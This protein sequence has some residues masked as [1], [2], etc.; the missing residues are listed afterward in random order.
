VNTGAAGH[1]AVV[2]R[3][4]RS[5]LWPSG[6]VVMVLPKRLNSTHRAR[7]L[8]LGAAWGTKI[9]SARAPTK[10]LRCWA[11]AEVILFC[12]GAKGERIRSRPSL[13]AG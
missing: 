5:V 2:A 8:L 6:T 9:V 13:K 7:V 4:D 3:L 1:Y 10:R 11:R 12:A